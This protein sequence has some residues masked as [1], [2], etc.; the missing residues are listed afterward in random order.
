MILDLHVHTTR[1]SSDSSLKPAEMVEEAVRAGLDGLCLT[2]HRGPW[3]RHEFAALQ[4]E[5]PHLFFANAMEVETTAGHI[6]VFGLNRPG[7]GIHDPE[8]LRRIA[9]AE[10]AF[11]V[12]AHPFRYLLSQPTSNLL[13]RG[14]LHIP[15]E[16]RD[17]KDH[18]IFDLVDAIEVGNGAT[19]PAENEFALEVARY[20]GKPTIGGS[21]AHSTHGLGRCVTVFRDEIT[22]GEMLLEVLRAHRFHAAV[23]IDGTLH[24]ME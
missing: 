7:G 19:A 4:E 20:V 24:P 18:W 8:T 3:D 1:G 12:L 14:E 23:R 11:V 6:T 15:Q 13:Y 17:V 5:H 9:D 2:E 22:D 16:P 10:G 21:D